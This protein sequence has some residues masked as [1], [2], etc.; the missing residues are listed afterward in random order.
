MKV[1]ECVNQIQ[2]TIAAIELSENTTP[3]QEAVADILADT[4]EVLQE[5]ELLEEPKPWFVT[6]VTNE[7]LAYMLS[8]GY[9]QVLDVENKMAMTFWSY[10]IDKAQDEIPDG[11]LIKEWGQEDWETPLYETYADWVEGR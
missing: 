1:N 6:K 9:G 8:K 4:V 5:L 10:P 3:L 2:Q 7:E 11:F